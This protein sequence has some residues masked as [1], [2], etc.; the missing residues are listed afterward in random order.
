[1]EMVITVSKNLEH[2]SNVIPFFVEKK[3]LTMQ[4]KLQFFV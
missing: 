4:S 1:M 2:N 3:N